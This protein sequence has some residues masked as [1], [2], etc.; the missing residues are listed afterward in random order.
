MR[1]MILV[2]CLL[3][4]GTNLCAQCDPGGG[5]GGT[6]ADVIVGEL[7]GTKSYGKSGGYYAYSVGTTA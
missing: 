7:T 1:F 3:F 6:G 4:T 5:P 2:L